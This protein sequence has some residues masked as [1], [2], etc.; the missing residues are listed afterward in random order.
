MA[1]GNNWQWRAVELNQAAVSTQKLFNPLKSSPTRFVMLTA[2]GV[3]LSPE[4]ILVVWKADAHKAQDHN[5]VFPLEPEFPGLS[6]FS[7][8]VP[9]RP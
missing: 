1:W 7:K 2:S 4:V 3:R 9:A 6:P 5:Y 8:C